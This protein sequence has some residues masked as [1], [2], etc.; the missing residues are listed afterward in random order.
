V[1][2]EYTVKPGQTAGGI[3]GN[4]DARLAQVFRQDDSQENLGNIWVG[5]ILVI[6]DI[7]LETCLSGGGTAQQPTT[8]PGP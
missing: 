1:D 5:D 2:C 4:F 3:A 7:P 6:K 8:T